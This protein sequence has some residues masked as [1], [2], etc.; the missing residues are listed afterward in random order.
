MKQ[1]YDL[2]K[3]QDL[4]HAQ[5]L[6]GLCEA[7][8]AVAGSPHGH[9]NLRDIEAMSRSALSDAE[10]LHDLTPQGVRYIFDHFGKDVRAAQKMPWIP[11]ELD[12]TK[13]VRIYLECQVFDLMS[14]YLHLIDPVFLA[15]SPVALTSA[16][17][18]LTHAVLKTVVV[19]SDRFEK[20][21]H[22]M[23]D[24]RVNFPGHDVF[25]KGYV[26]QDQ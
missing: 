2:I 5:A 9:V 10:A 15:D 6:E 25:L 19:G 11:L 1:P 7:I 13:M 3:T 14:K 12:A 16:R 20:L 4:I 26:Y 18:A 21:I 17:A 23:C 22:R 24:I 8:E